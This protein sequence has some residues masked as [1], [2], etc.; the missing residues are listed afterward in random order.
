MGRT[1]SPMSTDLNA[2]VPLSDDLNISLNTMAQHR[3][4]IMQQFGDGLPY[5]RDRIVH[6]ARFYMAQSAEAMLEAGKRLIILK[7]NEPHGDFINIV[8]SELSM[9]KRTAQVMMQASIKYLSPQ[10]E[11]KAQTFALLGKAKLFELMTEDDENLAELAD[12][13][14]VAGLTLDDVDRM[15]V[16]E[17]RQALREARETNAAQQRVLADKNEKIDSLSTRLEKK[18]RIQPPE[19]DEEVKKLRA[20]VT[21]LAVEAESA[22]AVRL[23]SAFETLCAYCAENM[24]DTPRDFMAGLVCQLEST[25]RSL[26]STFDLPDEPTGNAAPSWLTEPTPQINRLEA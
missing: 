7:E 4:E 5:E 22:I 18:S 23:S 25:A 19:P 2:E 1:K 17:L 8:E 16:R 21:A 14:T 20:E 12:G 13:G 11:S 6:E 15:S 3:V 26:R 10:L 9:S 24:I